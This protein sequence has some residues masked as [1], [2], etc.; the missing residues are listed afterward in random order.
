[1][2]GAVSRAILAALSL[3]AAYAAASAAAADEDLWTLLKAGGQVIVMRH[4][5]TDRS[6]GDPPSFRLDD[7]AMQ[8]NLSAEGRD[9]AQRLGAAFRA[10]AI[11]IGRVLS[12]QWCRCLETARL[13]FG[14]PT[15]WLALNSTF[16]NRELEPERTREVR[17][18]AGERPAG[19]NLVL[20]THQLNIAALTS[21]YPAEGELVVL[22]PL[23]GGRFRVAGRLKPDAL[24]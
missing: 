4:A 17:A 16:R 15:P 11:P 10:R 1:V 21:V 14:E 24:N 19:G 2:T 20:V 3:A 18:L 7:C 6:V 22:S 23:G 13:A 8:R 12:S 9:E 5:S